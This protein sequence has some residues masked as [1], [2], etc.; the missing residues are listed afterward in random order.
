MGEAS[1]NTEKIRTTF[2]ECANDVKLGGILG[3]TTFKQVYYSLLD[4]QKNRLNEL[5][6]EKLGH[7]LKSGS[8]IS[9]AFVYPDGIID[10]IAVL[11]DGVFDKEAWNIYADW[12]AYLNNALDA[13]SKRIADEF[14]G[15]PMTATSTGMASKVNHV[16]EYFP[17]VVSHRVHAEN[18][19]IGWRGKNSLIVNPIYSCMIRLS[20]VITN[21]P[22][23]RTSKLQE[24]CGDC[25]RCEEACTYI[26]N[27]E[28]LE[29]YREQCRIYLN[30]L[31]LNEEVCGKC[32]KAC[33][34]SLRLSKKPT[35]TNSKLDQV[36]YTNRFMSSIY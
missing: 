9:L 12:Y 33:V 10:H 15:I 14:N 22:L 21:A 28:K 4:V 34:H 13:T 20:G 25:T 27:R 26:K 7:L 35:V 5:V 3:V 29:D 36:Y 16:S 8:I 2:N 31:G 6:E 23:I 11:K 24:N 17:T 19:G 30:T 18:A 32:I 1:E